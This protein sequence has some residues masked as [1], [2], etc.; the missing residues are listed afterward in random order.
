MRSQH[1]VCGNWT[2]A[3]RFHV[4]FDGYERAILTTPVYSDVAIQMKNWRCEHGIRLYVT[5]SGWAEAS[6]VF[7]SRTN[8]GDMTLLIDEYFDTGTGPMNESDTYRAVLQRIGQTGP[9]CVLLTKSPGSAVAAAN[10]GIVP[11]LVVTHK[12]DY[13]LLG[14]QAKGIAVVRTLNEIEFEQ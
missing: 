10:V 4:W 8:Q 14:D 11:I 13:D 6:R 1:T 5:S 3:R 9:D 12:R 2:R 7:L